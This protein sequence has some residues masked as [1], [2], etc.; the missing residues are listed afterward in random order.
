MKGSYEF[1]ERSNM[2]IIPLIL[3]QNFKTKAWGWVEVDGIVEQAYLQYPQHVPADQED[4]L[5]A[6]GRWM[7]NSTNIIGSFSSRGSDYIN[8]TSKIAGIGMKK[9]K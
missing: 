5:K 3:E 9:S 2:D 1:A 7:S 4:P 6:L 8:L